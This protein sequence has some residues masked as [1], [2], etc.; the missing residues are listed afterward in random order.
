ME[1]KKEAKEEVLKNQEE[2]DQEEVV[3]RGKVGRVVEKEV[4]ISVP[5]IDPGTENV[6]SLSTT[7]ATFPLP[8][9]SS[10]S[11]SS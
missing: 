4:T 9:T 1:E 5:W 11:H 10:W 7:L 3:V 2:W 8:T 6:T